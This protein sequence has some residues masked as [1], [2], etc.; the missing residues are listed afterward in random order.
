MRRRI[1][2]CGLFSFSAV[3]SLSLAC[4]PPKKE[5]PPPVV[6]DAS[7]SATAVDAAASAATDAGTD[8]DA[9]PKKTVRAPDDVAA[10][11][12]DATMTKSGLRWKLLVPGVG[13][14][15]PGAR[16]RVT[17]NY[18]GWTPDGTM[19]DSTVTRG[20]PLTFALDSVIPGWTEGL[21]LMAPG[22]RRRFWIPKALAYGD[23][24]PAGAPQGNLVFD[25]EL[26][27]IVRPGKPPPVPE[28]LRNPPAT[29]KSTPSG[30]KYRVLRAGTG[31]TYPTGRAHVTIH[32]SGWDMKGKLFD[33]SLTRE[34][35]G[36]FTLTEVIQG[37][38]E[39]VVLMT[40]GEKARFWIPSGLAY[41]DS[42]SA[43]GA[44]AGPL[45]FDIELI[46]FKEPPI[47]PPAPH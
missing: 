7:T 40:V 1:G 24:P 6:A 19:F 14:E 26:L 47:R 20:E 21:Q 9:E 35:P 39:A 32:Y 45:V 33:S 13:Q 37:W 22:E 30:I 34:K 31:T 10:P 44:P 18:T 36:T 3:V 42:P 29:A 4:N 25:V 41:G 16:D 28:D 38:T 12:P 15:H 17:V 2:L 11:P 23:R 46:S 27:S 5:P 43:P 8:A